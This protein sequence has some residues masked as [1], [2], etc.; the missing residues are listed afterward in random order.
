[1]LDNLVSNVIDA[2]GAF[3]GMWEVMIGDG[4]C[5]LV[6]IAKIREAHELGCDHVKKE[7]GYRGCNRWMGRIRQCLAASSSL[8]SMKWVALLTAARYLGRQACWVGCTF[9]RK[10]AFLNAFTCWVGLVSKMWGR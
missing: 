7:S 6:E 10:L 9:L 2:F 4:E 3:Q 5:L 8:F 1:V